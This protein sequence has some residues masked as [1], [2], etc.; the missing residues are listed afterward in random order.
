[1]RGRFD[2]AEGNFHGTTIRIPDYG[3]DT[4]QVSS[5]VLAL[6]DTGGSWRRGG[7][8]LGLSPLGVFEDGA[9]RLFYEIYNLKADSTYLTAMTV[10][11]TGGQGPMPLRLEYRDLARPDPDGVVRENRAVESG[12]PAGRYRVTIEA[13]DPQAGRSARSER[14]FVVTR[15]QQG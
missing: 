2:T 3:G 11:S 5:V 4:L 15:R 14:E 8:S 12:L 6:P 7:H 9:F 1:V 13:T 10:E